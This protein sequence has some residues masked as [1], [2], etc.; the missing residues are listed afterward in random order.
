MKKYEYG[1]CRLNSFDGQDLDDLCAYLND[2]G[3][4]GWDV[5]QIEKGVLLLKREL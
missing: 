1:W 4:Q 3:Q 2:I 5:V